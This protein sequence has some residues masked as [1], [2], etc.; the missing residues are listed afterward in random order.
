MSH[1]VKPE[2]HSSG[3]RRLK[4]ICV[5]WARKDKRRMHLTLQLINLLFAKVSSEVISAEKK[6][7]LKEG[8]EGD[9]RHANNTRAGLKI[10][11]NRSY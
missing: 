4:R 9:L 2:V 6:V 10:T 5:N 3:F 8:K 7:I 11:G 1:P